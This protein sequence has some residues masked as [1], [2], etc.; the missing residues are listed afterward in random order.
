MAFPPA[1]AFPS[2]GPSAGS[3]ALDGP[4]PSPTPMGGDPSAGGSFSMRGLAGQIPSNQMPPEVLTGV[5]QSAQ[6]VSDIFDSWA[7]I[8]PDKGPQLALLKDMLQQFL[9]ELM[10]SGAGPTQ[11]TA[12]GPAFPG[13]GMDRGLAAAGAV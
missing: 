5:T 9:A 1:P 2:I 11:P 8:A 13:G 10:Q 4:P 7:Q 3:S 6:A 12:S